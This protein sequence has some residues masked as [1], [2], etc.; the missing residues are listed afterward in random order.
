MNETRT[1]PAAGALTRGRRVAA[2][3]LL[4]AVMGCVAAA[5][6]A[7]LY[8]Y[9]RGT[10]GWSPAHAVLVPVALDVAAMACALLG[11]D[12]IAKG[13]T[14]AGFRVLT[15]AFVALSA[16]VNWRHAITSGNLA[17][18][19]FFP[20][21]SLLAYAIVHEV[22]AK[23]RREV[24][25]DLAGHAH[26]EQV[27]RLPR[28]G[29]SAW[30]RYPARAFGVWSQSI[31]ARLARAS[32]AIGGGTRRGAGRGPAVAQMSQADAIRAA[33]AA[34]GDRPREVIAWLDGHGRPGVAASRVS[35]VVRRTRRAP[36]RAVTE[37]DQ[38]ANRGAQ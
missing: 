19:V 20:A 11:L 16:F 3:V 18:Q 4:V 37:V 27:E 21:M 36:L 13:E 31:E 23:Y 32:D 34:V 29:A 10:L 26:R 2:Y 5:S 25:R 9:A 1:E 12:S 8:A 22:F 24:T 35:D 30:A 38:G 15:A 28:L 6:W 33:I 14:A 7:G 17:E